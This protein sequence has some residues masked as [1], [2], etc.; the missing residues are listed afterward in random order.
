MRCLTCKY[1]H[2]RTGNSAATYEGCKLGLISPVLN[3][4]ENWG[5]HYWELETENLELR[6]NRKIQGILVGADLEL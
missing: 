5:C 4:D 1:A 3:L 6:K 2:V